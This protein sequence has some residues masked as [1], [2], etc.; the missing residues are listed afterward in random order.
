M[1]V[2]VHIKENRKKLAKYLSH[3]QE[4]ID[5]YKGV[6]PFW[7][8]IYA[9][10]QNAYKIK[11]NYYWLLMFPEAL[12]RKI[13]KVPRASYLIQPV[14]KEK[15]VAEWENIMK[16]VRKYKLVGEKKLTEHALSALY[17]EHAGLL[18]DAK[19]YMEEVK[20]IPHYVGL[21]HYAYLR[22]MQP[23]I[24]AIIERGEKLDV[25]EIGA[26]GG[27]L[28]FLLMGMFKDSIN[29]YTIIDLPQM[30]S[31]SAYGNIKF[32]PD[33]P[34]T[35]IENTDD[36]IDSKHIFC[37]ASNVDALRDKKY[38]L[39][40][41]THSFQEMDDSIIADYFALIYRSA[42]EGALFF[43][44]NWEQVKMLRLD[45]SEYCNSPQNYPYREGDEVLFHDED[46]FHGYLKKNYG[47]KPKINTMTSIRILGAERKSKAA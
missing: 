41:N 29:S 9:P 12:I 14:S 47:L 44:T 39:F 17:L 23:Y 21:R 40:L 28:K 45:G 18:E 19:T 6:N 4:H 27:L 25:L 13:N 24:E 2:F 8:G 42:K 36:I 34:I 20:I 31:L 46:I 16:P 37:P 11:Y 32:Y 22:Q 33:E 43:N 15:I 10:F 1:G 3:L 7:S 26:G 5:S 30:L 38:N 35:I